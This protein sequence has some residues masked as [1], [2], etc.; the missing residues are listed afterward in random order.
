[1]VAGRTLAGTGIV[2]AMAAAWAIAPA[3]GAAD[4]GIAPSR[5]SSIS[6]SGFGSFTPASGDP[7]L[8]AALARA[9]ISGNGFRFTPSSAG[10]PGSGAIA[11]AVSARANPAPAANTD[12]LAAVA[13][14]VSLAP[15][16][17][18][19]GVSVGWKRF[20]V[21]GDLAK[22]DLAAT[23]GSRDVADA[24]VSYVGRAFSGR[25]KAEAPRPLA[26]PQPRLVAEA[27][28]AA[29]DVGGAYS[30]TRN[31]DLTAGVRYKTERERLPQLTEN[32]RDSQS[33]YV[34][35]AFRF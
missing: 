18:N 5:P 4:A 16:A 7:R 19:L 35:T 22:V 2:A 3:S 8:A 15:I 28:N 24:G 1:M 11:V 21:S 17:Y 6:A 31:L 20:A 27:P 34:G 9:G 13:P 33:V 12:R 14:S 29:L 25:G 32:R 10:K 23:S 30:I 26:I